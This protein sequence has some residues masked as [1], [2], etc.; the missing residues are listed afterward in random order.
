MISFILCY[1]TNNLNALVWINVWAGCLGLANPPID[2][3]F[4]IID[5]YNLVDLCIDNNR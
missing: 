5:L 1:S 3:L 2:F 4:P